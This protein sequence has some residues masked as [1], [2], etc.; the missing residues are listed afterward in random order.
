MD[1]DIWIERNQ[2]APIQAI[3]R[4]AQLLGLFVDGEADLDLGEIVARLGFSRATAHRYCMSLRAVGLL[5]YEPGTGRYA[6]G[7]RIIELG[8]AALESLQ[9]LAIAEPYLHQ[10]VTRIDRTVVLSV[11]D[12]QAPVVVR[13]NDN[14]SMMVRIS[15]RIGSRLPPLQSAQG[16]VFLALS[17][18]VRRPFVHTA[19]AELAE[20][21]E[22]L[23]QV[24]EYGVS[25]R[26]DVSE[27]IRAIGAPVYRGEEVAATMAI[28][29]TQGTVPEQVDSPMI[30][31]LRY[32]SG[33]LSRALSE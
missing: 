29:G 16:H 20:I 19:G 25:I 9:I 11:W 31:E 15:V 4:A 26:A 17:E 21:R 28:V 8:T 6:L 24:R 32:I 3:D 5:R 33:E 2:T 14:T 1:R 10:L 18:S 13:V 7:A 12:G 27:G 23:D 30:R 22:D